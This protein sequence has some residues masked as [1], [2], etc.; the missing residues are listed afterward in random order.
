MTTYLIMLYNTKRGAE[1]ALTKY[2][3]S[4]YII[5]TE[6]AFISRH[7]MKWAIFG[8]DFNS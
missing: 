8:C 2:L 7:G 4:G 3:K 6:K 1:I 5:R